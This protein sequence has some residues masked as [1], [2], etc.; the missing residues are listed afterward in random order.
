MPLAYVLAKTWLGSPGRSSDTDHDNVDMDADADAEED[1]D[2]DN[3]ENHEDNEDEDEEQD[4]EDS[5]DSFGDP[6]SGKL[7]AASHGSL[8]APKA[9]VPTSSRGPVVSGPTSHPSAAVLSSL[10]S[11]KQDSFPL[12][13]TE[14]LS[15]SVYDIVPTIA[16]PH[17]TSINSVTATPDLRWVFTGGSDGYIRKFNWVE[18][19]NGKSMLTVAQK[20]PF[21]DSVTKA[22]VLMSYWENEDSNRMSS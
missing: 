4:Q 14:A 9:Q 19:A 21:V 6:R 15:A 13:R 22:G 8:L 12:V 10:D 20:H 17:S 16:A 11:N 3:D 2:P 5:Q 7:R 18:T 1:P